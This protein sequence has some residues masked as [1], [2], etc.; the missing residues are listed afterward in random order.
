MRGPDPSLRFASF[1][2]T[3]D[4]ETFPAPSQ[5]WA[6]R[7]VRLSGSV[8]GEVPL[9]RKHNFGG[10]LVFWGDAIDARPVLAV[11]APQEGARPVRENIL[12]FIPGGG[13]SLGDV[14]SIQGGVPPENIIVM[15]NTLCEFGTYV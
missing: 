9:E 12:A 14:R 1:R 4:T 15:Y 10:R 13:Y 7:V 5:S 8:S 3:N 6:V 2:M 11:A